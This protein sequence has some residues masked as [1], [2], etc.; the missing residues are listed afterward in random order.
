MSLLRDDKNFPISFSHARLHGRLGSLPNIRSGTILAK[1]VDVGTTETTLGTGFS[2]FYVY[3]PEAATYQI[4]SESA[5]DTSDG[6]GA[7]LVVI[8]GLDANYDEITDVVA[9][10]GQTPV[11][12]NLNFLRFNSMLI[13]SAGSSGH[14]VGNIWIGDTFDGGIPDNKY[15]F[16]LETDNISNFGSYTIPRNYQFLGVATYIAVQAGRNI[17]VGARVVPFG[18]PGVS[19]YRVAQNYVAAG[20]P[21]SHYY[22]DAYLID[23][24]WSVE[25]A[26][27]SD[28]GTAQIMGE[29]EYYLVKKSF[30]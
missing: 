15:C 13:I 26:A 21:W 17:I 25:Y 3:P 28:I 18:F 6:V 8:N 4:A 30:P 19:G 29:A 23:E 14:N 12:L 27:K 24:K 22:Q 7:R 9:L 16:L 10:N 11:N 1:G 20:T 5:S 2:G